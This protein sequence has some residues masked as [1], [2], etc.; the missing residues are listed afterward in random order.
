MRRAWSPKEVADMLGISRQTLYDL[1]SSGELFG[2]KWGP[3]WIIPEAAIQAYLAG[4]KYAPPAP[5]T[6]PAPEMF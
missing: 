5:V 4:T 2:R 6:T 1:L 3:R